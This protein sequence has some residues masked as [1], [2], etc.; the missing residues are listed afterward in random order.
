MLRKHL[1]RKLRTFK[2]KT[3]QAISYGEP[4]VKESIFGT[5]QVVAP[6]KVQEVKFKYAKGHYC[7]SLII[8]TVPKNILTLKTRK[9]F[10]LQLETSK[11]ENWGNLEKN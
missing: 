1:Q 4:R 10:F 5:V 8:F 2:E 6:L 7:Y 9:L 11:N 3:K